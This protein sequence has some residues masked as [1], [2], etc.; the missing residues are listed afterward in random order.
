MASLKTI[1]SFLDKELDINAFEDSSH[2]GLQVEGP[3]RVKRVCAGVDAS[4]DFFEK[5]AERKA[6]LLICHHGLSWN[7]SLKRITGL[8]YRK[9]KFLMDSGMAL[10]A[11]HLPLDAHPKLGNNARI[12]DALGL[13]S[14]SKFGEYHGKE[15]GFKGSLPKPISYAAFKKKAG[16]VF[17]NELRAMDFGKKTIRTVAVCSGGAANMVEEAALR[18]AD[19]FVSGE[20]TLVAYHMAREHGINAIFAGHYATEAFGVKALAGLLAG[21]F[22]IKSE[23]LDMKIEF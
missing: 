13:K 14:R 20:A 17:K 16:K 2:N 11:G 12:C 22:D 9:L 1:V 21:K 23:F 19:V 8:N 3:G 4:L 6:D 15:I 7:D 10:Y 5:A 18:G